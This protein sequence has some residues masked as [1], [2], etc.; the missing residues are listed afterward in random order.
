M[1]LDEPS[2]Y[3]ATVASESGARVLILDK[4]VI[5]RVFQR[6]FDNSLLEGGFQ[7]RSLNSSKV[8]SSDDKK[9]L[10]RNQDWKRI[11][12]AE[13]S[14]VAILGTGGFGT[15]T[16][17]LHKATGDTFALK[18]LSKGYITQKNM[19]RGVM[20]EK[21]ILFLCNSHFIVQAYQ[22]LRS[23]THLYFLMEACLGKNSIFPHKS[24][25][26]SK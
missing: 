23:A 20:R 12:F 13:L 3:T 14:E 21:E 8:S 19:Q 16:L 6:S 18:G 25:M 1:V 11:E 22:T 10:F 15:V 2:S 4:A 7:K 17:Q 9:I 24:H 26:S 5:Q